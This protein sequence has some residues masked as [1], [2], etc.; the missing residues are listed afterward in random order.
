MTEQRTLGTL[1]LGILICIFSTCFVIR[2]YPTKGK[3][4]DVRPRRHENEAFIL[5]IT[6]KL[7]G[8]TFIHSKA[9]MQTYARFLF[10]RRSSGA[11]VVFDGSSATGCKYVVDD[12]W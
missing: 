11:Q 1:D 3:D 2:D 10:P 9:S 5:F 12:R 7:C 8:S 6:S 4:S